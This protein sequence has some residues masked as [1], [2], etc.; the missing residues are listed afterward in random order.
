MGS[1]I[2]PDDFAQTPPA[3]PDRVSVWPLEDGRYGLDVTYTGASGYELAS[4]LESMLERG[5]LPYSFRQELGG[6]WTI[7]L[8]L[9]GGLVAKSVAQFVGDS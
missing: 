9:P 2:G 5:G 7:R 6:A 1:L 8:T 4:R 3:I